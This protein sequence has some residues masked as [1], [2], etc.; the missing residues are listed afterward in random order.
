MLEVEGTA[1]VAAR[2]CVFDQSYTVEKEAE[3]VLAGLEVVRLGGF[4][5]LDRLEAA[6]LGVF[7][8]SKAVK[9]MAQLAMAASL[10]GQLEKG[11]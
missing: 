5:K 8:A 6:E 1:E 9:T 4:E 11:S 2:S 10:P 7:G 3:A